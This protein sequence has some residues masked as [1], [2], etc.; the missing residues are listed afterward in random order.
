MRLL[1]GFVL[2]LLVGCSEQTNHTPEK[3]LSSGWVKVYFL[4][5]TPEKPVKFY[6]IG[7]ALNAIANAQQLPDYPAGITR[8]ELSE[9]EFR[10]KL[11]ITL[12]NIAFYGQGA[13]ATKIVFDDFA[14]RVN[15]Q[16]L[17]MGTSASATLTLN[18]QDVYFYDLTIENDFDFLYYDGLDEAA[19]DRV[20]AMQAVALYLAPGSDR[21]YFNRVSFLG[22]Q[23]TL[24]ADGDRAYIRDSLI[25]GNVDFIFGRGNLVILNS[26]IRSRAR[27]KITTPSGYVTA[28]STK[29][30]SEF[31]ITVINSRLTRDAAVPDHSVAL[32]RPWHP[33]MTF[34]DGR[35][36]DPSVNSK[37]VFIDTW[38]DKHILPEAW[39]WMGG[40]TKAGTKEPIQPD[41]Q[42]FFEM[43]SLGPGAQMSEK[44]RV[45]GDVA[46]KEYSLANILGE[47]S[48]TVAELDEVVSN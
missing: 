30:A 46:R 16:G 15:A 34:A 4:S 25:A 44:R 22:Y 5:E 37:A 48:E 19:S 29:A 18:A 28:P 21:I 10:E 47:W 13:S 32:G 17:P 35:Y 9:G 38:M 7:E 31:G 2:A 11:T 3:P 41:D 40:T 6:R 24:F 39:Y 27:A 8:I 45:L 36:A 23:D 20:N 12:N 33:T 26:D 1:L 43:A 42:R 14:G